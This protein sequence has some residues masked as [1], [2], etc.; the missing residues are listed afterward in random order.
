M[1]R[2]YPPGPVSGLPEVNYPA[3]FA[4]SDRLSRPGFVVEN[5]ATNPKCDSWAGYMR[6]S[7]AQLLTCDAVALLP[8]W[9]QSRGAVLEVQVAKALGMP[10]LFASDVTKPYRAET[11]EGW[12]HA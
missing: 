8:D 1:N 3:V 10:V 6:L 12:A 9:M 2:L 7:L 5:P 4:E 11:S